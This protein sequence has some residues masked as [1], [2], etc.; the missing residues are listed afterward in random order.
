M[1]RHWSEFHFL[2]CILFD[3]NCL[4]VSSYAA[5]MVSL[6]EKNNIKIAKKCLQRVN[7]LTS[8][9]HGSDEIQPVNAKEFLVSLMIRY[10]PAHIFES[11]GH[12][13]NQLIE[14]TAPLL[15]V[16]DEILRII[17]S[18]GSFQSVSGEVTKEFPALLKMYFKRFNEWKIADINKMK[19]KIKRSIVSLHQATHEADRIVP[20][21]LVGV[22][23]QI[24]YL[25]NKFEQVA[26][27][28][29]VNEFY[30][31]LERDDVSMYAPSSGELESE[32]IV[33]ELLLDPTYVHLRSS[34]SEVFSEVRIVYF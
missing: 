18:T 7:I 13:E 3:I 28:D 19:F 31:Q 30:E 2:L 29:E 1:W 25:R 33:H 9:R 22:Y 34:D 10:H 12:L 27:A 21:L 11:I 16:F 20:E 8:I 23:D 17:Q 24:R 14:A 4:G 5:V 26:S 6:S 15:M 32:Q